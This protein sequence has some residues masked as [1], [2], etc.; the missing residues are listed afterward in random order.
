VITA[1]HSV[2]SGTG[3]K[4][5]LTGG[6]AGRL[7]RSFY[8]VID[9]AFVQTMEEPERASVMAISRFPAAGQAV[10]VGCQS[11]PVNRTVVRVE[12]NM[13]VVRTLSRSA[14]LYT[15]QCCSPGDSGA[16]V[17]ASGGAAVGLYLG[18]LDTPDIGSVG[19]VLSFE[20]ALFAL[21]V[22]AFD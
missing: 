21:D 16:L 5:S 22:T 1:G 18:S 2:G 7:A 8:P 13:G 4:V 9:A 20:Q 3:R 17:Q 19:R 12:D 11:T 15:D 14:L 6:A 10:R